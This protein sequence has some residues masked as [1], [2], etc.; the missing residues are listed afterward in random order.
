MTKYIVH[1]INEISELKKVKNFYGME[2]DVRDKG[3]K[4][5]LSH[6]PNSN[7]EELSKF[8]KKIEKQILFINR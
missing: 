8:I 4:I 7:G 3:N 1:R 5:I 6:D 2:I